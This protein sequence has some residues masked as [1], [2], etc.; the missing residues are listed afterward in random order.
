MPSPYLNFGQS[1]TSKPSV[2]STPD[3]NKKL[4]NNTNFDF[5][6]INLSGIASI[7]GVIGGFMAHQDY[8]KYK[9]KMLNME[10]KRIAR[11]QKR[12]DAF[13]SDMKKAWGV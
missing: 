8:K 1:V 3:I 13:E 4:N 5:S 7:A 9:S 11:E 6:D 12:Q 2:F 10:K